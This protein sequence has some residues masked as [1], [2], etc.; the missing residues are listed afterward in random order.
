MPV[1]CYS[2]R[3]AMGDPTM[4]VERV[5]HMGEAPEEISLDDGAIA[6]RDF[7][8]E[9]AHVPTPKQW[10]Q[11]MASDALAINPRQIP[12]ATAFNKANGVPT[13]EYDRIGRPIFK[14][15]HH[16]ALYGRAWKACD[17]S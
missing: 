15:M 5:Y 2:V 11:G 13:T 9:W 3:N 16:R 7:I 12:E 10:E 14:S 4:T 17:Y 8:A 6:T 1:Y